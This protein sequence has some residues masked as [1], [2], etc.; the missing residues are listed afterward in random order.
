MSG[1]PLPGELFAYKPVA[2]DVLFFETTRDIT[3]ENLSVVRACI[4]EN[5]PEGVEVIVLA[6]VS[7]AKVHR[8]RWWRR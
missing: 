6:G 1:K 2:G 5:L 3:Q 7:V 8:H 4:Q